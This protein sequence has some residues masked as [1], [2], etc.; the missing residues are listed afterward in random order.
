MSPVGRA[1]GAVLLLCGVFLVGAARALSKKS[2]VCRAHL[3]GRAAQPNPPTSY[4][5]S[6]NEK[7]T[8]NYIRIAGTC[9]ILAGAWL[10]F[11]GIDI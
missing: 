2:N 10:A 9:L 8:S 4:E 6:I 7:I 5:R 3:Q 11:W 1:T